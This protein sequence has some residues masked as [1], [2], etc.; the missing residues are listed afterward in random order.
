MQAVK[1]FGDAHLYEVIRADKPAC[2]FMDVDFVLEDVESHERVLRDVVKAYREFTGIGDV[3]KVVTR[4]VRK[5]NP[6]KGSFHVLF[7]E[8]V[9]E[10][11]HGGGDNG[12][13]KLMVVF[14]QW[15]RRHCPQLFVQDKFVVDTSVYSRN[16][17]FRLPGNSKKGQK[18]ATMEFVNPEDADDDRNWFVQNPM[19]CKPEDELKFANVDEVLGRWYE[20]L[21]STIGDKVDSYELRKRRCKNKDKYE[22]VTGWKRLDLDEVIIRKDEDFMD[23]L[24]AAELKAVDWET[25]FLPVMASLARTVDK[26]KLAYWCSTSKKGYKEKYGPMIDASVAMKDNVWVSGAVAMR[27]LR[28]KVKRVVDLR[29]VCTS[30]VN[31]AVTTIE[32]RE[33]NGWTPL[34]SGELFNRL[35]NDLKGDNRAAVHA[36]R[37]C[38]FITGKMG[39]S[40]TSSILKYAEM[41]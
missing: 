35:A 13:K 33:G 26:N 40:K 2:A 29:G 31:D 32:A 39:A 19:W 34:D 17:V 24:N 10:Y 8:V 5:D 23:H 30:Y 27:V 9:F 15:C 11:A 6:T 22:L 1:A 36:P 28:M 4:C 18:G 16:R 7:P 25:W 21:G 41:N 12:Q 20:E 38:F 14:R 3:K 37:R